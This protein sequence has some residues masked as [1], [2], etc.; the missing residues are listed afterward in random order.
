MTNTGSLTAY[1]SAVPVRPEALQ[2]E[3]ATGSFIGVTSDG[4]IVQKAVEPQISQNH[5]PGQGDCSSYQ[6][7]ESQGFSR[8]LHKK[9]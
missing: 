8:E 6:A 5:Q 3:G 1:P 4:S 7:K 2:D 9:K